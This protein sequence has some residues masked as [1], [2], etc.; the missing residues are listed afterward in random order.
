[1]ADVNLDEKIDMKDILLLMK[2]VIG[3]RDLRLGMHFYNS[4]TVYDAVI[5]S[6]VTIYIYD[7]AGRELG[8]RLRIHIYVGRALHYLALSRCC[9][10]FE[11][12][13]SFSTTEQGMT[14]SMCQDIRRSLIWRR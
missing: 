6:V 14:R 7:G 13:R 10:S 4:S 12:R 9:G 3:G 11:N 2:E 5:D 8:L 1:M